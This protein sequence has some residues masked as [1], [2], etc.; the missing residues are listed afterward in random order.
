M[1]LRN[2][3][4]LGITKT[5]DLDLH[6]TSKGVNCCTIDNVSGSEQKR[7]L[8]DVLYTFGFDYNLLAVVRMTNYGGK[9]SLEVRT[10][11]ISRNGKC[12]DRSVHSIH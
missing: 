5:H 10:C 8:H 9:V 12:T 7:K 1:E 2:T 11:R 6:A 4:S 3:V